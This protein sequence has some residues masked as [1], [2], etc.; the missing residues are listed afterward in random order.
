MRIEARKAD[1]CLSDLRALGER[2]MT[3]HRPMPGVN[4]PQS[5]FDEQLF[6]VRGD[7]IPLDA[8]LKATGLA[9]SGGRAKA[10]V[11]EGLVRVDGHVELR[12]TCKL[13]PGQVVEVAGTRVRLGAEPLSP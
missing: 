8:L 12:K 11:A 6:A 9:P 3:H 1:A 7:H 13:R 4:S 10:M 5:P 2:W